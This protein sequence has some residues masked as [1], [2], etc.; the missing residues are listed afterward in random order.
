MSPPTS[1][2][3]T[4]VWRDFL[5]IPSHSKST[6]SPPTRTLT[7]APRG[8]ALRGS[9]LKKFSTRG[10]SVNRTQSSESDVIDVERLDDVD[11]PVQEVVMNEG[12]VSSALKDITA[13]TCPF[14][15][16]YFMNVDPFNEHMMT[17]FFPIDTF[18]V[19]PCNDD[20]PSLKMINKNFFKKK[21]RSNSTKEHLSFG[22]HN[23]DR[24][25]MLVGKKPVK[26]AEVK[27]R[28]HK[29]RGPHV[30]PATKHELNMMKE[31]LRLET[32]QCLECGLEFVTTRAL[33]NH[34]EVENHVTPVL[35]QSNGQTVGL[36][37]CLGCDREFVTV[38]ALL[39]HNR[40]VH[41]VNF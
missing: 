25:A 35:S 32:Y 2:H 34:M 27:K 12:K 4:N 16:D 6:E 36:L 29:S 14:C 20:Q 41:N 21:A 7:Q 10:R 11:P 8:I 40:Q 37:L 13:Y 33:R 31:E 39:Q 15:G 24:K 19:P 28:K 5:D 30:Y 22:K 18:R 17:H 26:K 9:R 38:S 23:F 1:I 3:V